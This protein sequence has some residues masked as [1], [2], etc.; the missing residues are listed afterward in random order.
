[1][2]LK[3]TTKYILGTDP[4]PPQPGN[5]SE[6]FGEASN[7]LQFD[8]INDFATVSGL[9]KLKQDIQKILLTEKG[10][11]TLFPLYGTDISTLVGQKVDI[12]FIRAKL[13]QQI[14]D[15]LK[16]LQYINRE[17]PN[18]DE[19]LDTLQSISIE[20]ISAGVIE[21]QLTVITASSKNLST[22]FVITL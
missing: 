2:D 11:N 8:S 3:L 15:A 18:L 12:N 14:I 16:V 4:V 21:V 9:T 20:E 1:M 13:K 5:P 17:N 7:D 22:G 10:A 19:Q 6:Y